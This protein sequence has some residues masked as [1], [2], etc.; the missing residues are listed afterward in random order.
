MIEYTWAVYRYGNFNIFGTPH[1]IFIHGFRYDNSNNIKTLTGNDKPIYEVSG[2]MD[3]LTGK[4][5]YSLQ[6]NFKASLGSRVYLHIK[7]DEYNVLQC[8]G[9]M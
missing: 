4:K 9:G 7:D 2:I 5:I 1:R 3:R 8:G 6:K